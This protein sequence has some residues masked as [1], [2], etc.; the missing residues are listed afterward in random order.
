MAESIHDKVK[1]SLHAA[2]NLYHRLVLLVGK[3]GSG[4]SRVLR[5]VANETESP[6]TNIN[7]EVSAKLLELPVRQRARRVESILDEIAERGKPPVVLDNLEILFDKDLGQDPMRLLLKIS[8][9]RA[10]LASWSGTL[11]SGKI[12]YAEPG[13]PEHSSHDIADAGV[14]SMSGLLAGAAPNSLEAGPA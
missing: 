3:S 6:V 11:D 14:V 8:R 1:R 13:H 10:V 2:E 12:L 7:L 4:K 5:D 9:N